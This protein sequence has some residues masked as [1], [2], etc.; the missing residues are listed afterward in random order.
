MKYLFRFIRL[1]YT[2]QEI[3]KPA[4]LFFQLN[5]LLPE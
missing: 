3:Y 2:L 5:R 1:L 4:L